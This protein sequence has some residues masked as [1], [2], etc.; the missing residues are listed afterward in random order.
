MDVRIEGPYRHRSGWRCRLAAHGKRVWCAAAPTQ[1]GAMRN[2]EAE[3]GE[4]SAAVN[5]TVGEL[6]D[7]YLGHLRLMGRKDRSIATASAELRALVG[8]IDG[9]E[10]TG[11][12][13]RTAKGRYQDLGR[14]AAATH[15][16]ALS[17]G[18]SCWAWA[19]EE[20][21][22]RINPWLSVKPV[23]RINKGKPQL[24]LDEAR[25]LRDACLAELAAES[26][27]ARAADGALAVALALLIGVRSGEITARVVRDIDDSGRV[28]R[29]P[30][31]KTPAGRRGIEIPA[32][33]QPSIQARTAGRSALAPLIAAPANHKMPANWVREQLHRLCKAAGIPEVCPH[34]LRGGWATIAYDA[35]ALSHL[36]ARALGH[37]SPEITEAHYASR[38]S[39]EGAKERRHLVALKGGLK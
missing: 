27:P 14:L 36:V 25:R 11:V 13:E 2:A 23:G 39:V 32:E 9:H 35:G 6:C 3:V 29:V 28:F 33:L 17:R 1:Q 34:A 7:R 10:V 19:I 5:L 15:R 37:A 30:D 20:G 18:R 26:W 8:P 22:T 16:K 38:E 31:S 12:T 21:I 24:T 4:Y